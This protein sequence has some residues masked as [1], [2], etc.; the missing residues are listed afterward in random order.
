MDF[1][2]PERI[3]IG[4]ATIRPTLKQKLVPVARKS[5]G[6]NSG[7]YTAYPACMHSVKNPNT[8]NNHNN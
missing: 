7:K 2:M 6:N 8:G 5:L 3:S 4:A 1:T